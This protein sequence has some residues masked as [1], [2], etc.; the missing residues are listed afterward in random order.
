M[1]CYQPQ[2]V[3]EVLQDLLMNAAAGVAIFGS[4][5]SYFSGDREVGQ[6]I[7]PEIVKAAKNSEDL[8]GCN[9]LASEYGFAGHVSTPTAAG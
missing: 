1:E 9:F 7:A 6:L 4:L 8:S 3:G 2:Q 5:R